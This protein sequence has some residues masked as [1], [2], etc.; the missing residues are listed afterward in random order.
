MKWIAPIF[1][2][3]LV[4]FL[5]KRTEEPRNQNLVQE[6][7]PIVSFK[8]EDVWRTNNMLVIGFKLKSGNYTFKSRL[9][10]LDCER[11]NNKVKIG[12]MAKVLYSPAGYKRYSL[13]SI[14]IDGQIWVEQ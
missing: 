13:V 2:F 9:S 8:C 10:N 14:E 3:A 11:F 6:T 4:V 12:S 7:L 1:I 5:L